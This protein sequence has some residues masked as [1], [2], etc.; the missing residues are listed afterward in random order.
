MP[1]ESATHISDLVVTNPDGSTDTK[2]T[3][4]DHIRLIKTVLQTDF[5][6]ISGVVTVTHTQINSV[7]ASGGLYST[8]TSTT[9]LTIG[10]GA[11]TLTT[12]GARGFAV[13][14]L[15]KLTSDA[16]VANYMIGTVTAYNSSTGAMSVTV[17]TVGGSGT[18]ADWSITIV[19]SPSGVAESALDLLTGTAIASAATINLDSASGN[20]VHITGTTPITAVT[21]TRGPRTLIFD[22]ALTLTHHATTNKLP[23]GANITTA[24]GDVAIYE[25]DG[26]AVRCVSYTRAS[27]EPVTSG[28]NHIVEAHTGNGYGAVATKIPRL[29]TVMTNTG[30]AITYADSAN[31]GASFT[32]NEPGL[33]EVFYQAMTASGLI[34]ISLNSAELTKSIENVLVVTRVGLSFVSGAAGSGGQV[35]S[36]VVM[37]T[38]GDVIRP[39]NDGIVTDNSDR[40]IFSIRKIGT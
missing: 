37:L 28:G 29:T 26:S 25:G 35:I 23:G 33:Y 9:S 38:A 13:G 19:A 4:D 3:L 30:T 10:T 5:P 14:Q 6:G 21:L 7:A 20:R 27:G 32:I 34:G 18:L 12:Q 16:S 40:H 24:A 22:G 31:N 15:V 17:T 11:K 2:A 8:G 36:R 1:L 39:H